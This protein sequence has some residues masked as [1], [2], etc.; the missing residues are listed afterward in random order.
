LL[1]VVRPI[2]AVAHLRLNTKPEQTKFLVPKIGLTVVFDEIAVGL[3]KD[4]VCLL[5]VKFLVPKIGLTV[6][7]DEIAVGLSKD[8]VSEVQS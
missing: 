2:S 8:Q 1:A 4:Q 6:V 7:F 5:I 3:S